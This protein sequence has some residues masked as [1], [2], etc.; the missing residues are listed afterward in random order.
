M[1]KTW[2]TRWVGHVAVKVEKCIRCFDGKSDGKKQLGKP[3][4]RWE[5][6]IK[7]YM[8]RQRIIGR[9]M[10]LSGSGEGQAAASCEP[11]REPL[12]FMK[13]GQFLDYLSNC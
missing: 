1:I 11:G 12:R 3:R 2:R 8:K 7:N 4:L 5:D 6:N 10:D 9:K 13:C